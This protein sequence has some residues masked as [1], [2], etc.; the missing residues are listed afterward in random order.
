MSDYSEMNNYVMSLV[1]DYFKLFKKL[2]LLNESISVVNMT[3]RYLNR[4][5]Y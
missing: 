5:G 2:R 4:P 3:G 1:Y